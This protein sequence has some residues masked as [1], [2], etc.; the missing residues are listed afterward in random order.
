MTCTDQQGVVQDMAGD[1]CQRRGTEGER[2]GGGREAGNLMGPD[3]QP[4]LGALP[5]HKFHAPGL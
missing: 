5:V 2:E 4:G 3:R 1:Q